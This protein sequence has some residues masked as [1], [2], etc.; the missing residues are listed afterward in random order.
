MN[1]Q[2]SP[3]PAHLRASLASAALGLATL[4]MSGCFSPG[5]GSIQNQR[6]SYTEVLA[7]TDRE[8]LLVNI[9][10]LAYCDAP[11]FLQVSGVTASPSIEYGTS[12]SEPVS[13][14]TL[15]LPTGSW[16]WSPAARPTPA[17]GT[18][19]SSACRAGWP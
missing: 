10:R 13:W 7:L 14:N 12:D 1:A 11:V 9:V 2:Q 15:L 18:S 5:P 4:L 8:E 16:N 17:A 6:G 3:L 19:T